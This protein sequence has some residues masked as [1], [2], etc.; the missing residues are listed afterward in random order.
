MFI[1]AEWLAAH[2]RIPLTT[3][4]IAAGTG[5]SKENASSVMQQFVKERTDVER[6]KLGVYMY[7]PGKGPGVRPGVVKA[8]TAERRRARE[9][10]GVAVVPA[11]PQSEAKPEAFVELLGL[12]SSGGDRIVRNREGVVFKLVDI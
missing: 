7:T 6:L 4:E 2:S 5:M 9:R 10:N 3:A 8:H 11:A 1:V 12:Q